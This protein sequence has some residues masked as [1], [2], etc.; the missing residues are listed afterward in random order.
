M[1]TKGWFGKLIV[2]ISDFNQDFVNKTYDWDAAMQQALGKKSTFSEV[3]KEN[4]DTC[5]TS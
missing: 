4:K 1:Y 5:T 3:N 2:D